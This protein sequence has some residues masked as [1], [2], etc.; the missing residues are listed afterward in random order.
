[1]ELNKF[2]HQKQK[3][4]KKFVLSIPSE[5]GFQ[6]NI[7][8]DYDLEDPDKHYNQ[9]GG[10][11]YVLENEGK[12]VGTIAVKNKG[13]SRAEIKRLYIHKDYRGKHLGSLLVDKALSFCKDSD[14]QIIELDTWKRFKTAQKLY[15]N[16]GFQVTKI[17]GEQIFMEKPL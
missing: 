5:F 11:F 17:V 15:Q 2:S 3:K 4:V 8:L 13:D 16:Y 9:N 14:F 1:M 10:V 6:H 7:D 12:V